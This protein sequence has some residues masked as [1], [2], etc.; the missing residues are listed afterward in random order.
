[1]DETTATPGKPKA[2]RKPLETGLGSPFES[3]VLPATAS[4]NE[5]KEKFSKALDEAKAGAQAL[6]RQAQDT[7][8]VYREKLT[9]KSDALLEEAKVMTGQAKD[10]AAELAQ[11]G[12]ARAVEGISAVSKIVSENAAT[13]DEKLGPKFGD[14]ARSA[15]RTMDDA[16]ARL[17]AKE[18][19]ELGNDARELVRKSPGI[20]IGIA[21]AAG[22]FLSRLFKGSGKSD[23]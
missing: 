15:A 10:K 17:D 1:M 3:D 18:L 23:S 13:I 20:A 2:A 6:T 22:F 19:G 12:K 16:A 14:Y 8:D 21:A 7:A 11:E 9:G 5:A 4:G